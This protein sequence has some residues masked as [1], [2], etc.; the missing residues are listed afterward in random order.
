MSVRY[1]GMKTP[2]GWGAGSRVIL[3]RA[4]RGLGC[5]HRIVLI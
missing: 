2:T 3:V 1:S 5:A 4:G